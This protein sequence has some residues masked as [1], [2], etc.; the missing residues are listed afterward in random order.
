MAAQPDAAS[1]SGGQ[2]QACAGLGGAG[3]GGAG[4]GGAGLGGAGLGGVGAAQ[5]YAWL[6]NLLPPA[7]EVR[8]GLWSI[9]VPWPDSGLR[10][11]L[12]YLVSGRGGPALIDT[13]W[14]T[15]EGWD[16]LAERVAQTGHDV[17]ELK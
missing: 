13:G 1:G 5:R 12:A 11:T 9:P 10:Y 7:E 4:L 14:P 17:T 2:G 6:E 16:A 3:L 8:S 15:D